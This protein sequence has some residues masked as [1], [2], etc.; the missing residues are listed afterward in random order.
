MPRNYRKKSYRPGYRS[1]GKMVYGDAQKA[2]RIAQSVKALLNVEV[3]NF[4]VQL[5]S[6][7][8]TDA[9]G[10][11][12]LC[13]IPQ[14][15]TSNTRDGS[16]VKM[17]GYEFNYFIQQSSAAVNADFIRVMLVVDKQT[18][19]A[20]YLAADLLDDIT[21]LDSIVTP[22]NLDNMKRFTVLYDRVHILS[23]GG[24]NG[25]HVK[26]YFKKDL[27]IRY[28]ASTSA[29]ADLTSNS[30]SLLTVASTASNDPAITFFGRLRY[31]DN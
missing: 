13:N 18:N 31:V 15:D 8:I 22:R 29:I 4:D 17:I 11:T 28:D 6:S 9:I 7:V 2:L 26:K 24:T 14:G 25:A 30:I 12:Q 20:I 1:C 23:K 19:Q 21:N 3:K 10:I 16:Q 5:N 27:L